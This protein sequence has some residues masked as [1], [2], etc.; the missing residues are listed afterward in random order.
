[1]CSH[2]D[3]RPIYP[4]SNITNG[5]DY[6][7]DLLWRSSLEYLGASTFPA[8]LNG[9]AYP[10]YATAGE[11]VGLCPVFIHM[12]GEESNEAGIHAYAPILQEAGVYHEIHIW[13]G[14]DHAA[15]NQFIASDASSP[16]GD[17]HKSIVYGN[18]R[19]CWQYDLRRMW[20]QDLV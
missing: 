3:N 19:D 7:A 4:T 10:I 5:N 1:M 17:R 18:I 14:S 15:L 16:Y 8:K 12:D 9:E 2:V 13:G 11:T 20:I 6:N